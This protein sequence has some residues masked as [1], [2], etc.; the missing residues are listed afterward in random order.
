MVRI[1]LRKNGPYVIE[2]DEVTIV[3]WEGRPY[4]VDRRPIAL[5][6]CGA[7]TRKPFCDGTHSRIGFDA[8]EAA[9]GPEAADRPAD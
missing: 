2:S 4:H 7:S 1:R 3:D 5:C 6:R 8:G 9:A